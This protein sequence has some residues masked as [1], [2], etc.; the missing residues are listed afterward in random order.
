MKMFMYKYECV[1]YLYRNYR[2]IDNVNYFHFDYRMP[3]MWGF[4]GND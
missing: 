1:I 3:F 2:H 4:V